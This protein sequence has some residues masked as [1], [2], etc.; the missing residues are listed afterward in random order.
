MKTVAVIVAHPDDETLWAGGTLL[1]H[2]AWNV[3]ILALCRA[4][5]Q[6]RAPR[7]FQVLKVLGAEGCIGDL[8]DGPEQTPLPD[9]EV[10]GAILR[11][12]PPTH[13]DRIIS[14]HPHGEYTRHRRHEEIGSAVNALW[15]EGRILA[16]EL[17]MFAYED[18]GKR[19]LPQ[20]IKTA[21]M[22][23]I[24]PESIWQRKYRIM[25]ATYGFEKQSWEAATTPRAEAF[26][27][28]TRHQHHLH[29]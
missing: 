2:P 20:P 11:L 27:Q 4:S 28:R 25:T 6:D 5:D 23:R 9:H 15:H 22:Y 24:L 16:Q 8:D 29:F 10:Q 7:F 1:S 13:F 3:Y 14:H 26:W 19:Y 21:D 18:G 17:W 12:L